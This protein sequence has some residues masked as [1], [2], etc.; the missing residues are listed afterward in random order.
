MSFTDLTVAVIHYQTPELLDR[1]L[2]RLVPSVPGARVLVVD[3]GDAAPLPARW[4]FPG[5]ELIRVAN[6]SFA[7]AVNTALAECRTPFFAHLNADVFVERSTV[8][9]LLA[10]LDGDARI[11]MTGPLAIGATGAWQDQGLPYR[12]W[13]WRVSR[14]WRRAGR[15]NGGRS[16]GFMTVPWLSGCLQVVRMAAV[17]A[18]GPLDDSQRFT[19]EETD[20][21]LR[22]A[23]HGYRSVLVDS[24]AVHLGG[25]STPGNPA[26]LIEGLRGSMVV[27]RRYAPAWRAAV[28]RYAVWGWA[29]LTAVFGLRPATRRTART[30]QQMF[31]RGRFDEA[32]FGETLADPLLPA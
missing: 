26:F 18:A 5:T 8:A 25:A 23:R 24:K 6:H 30:I 29:T 21:C 14:G 27:S 10:V 16:V 32:V 13:Q 9:D 4:S 7:R 28:Q 15:R 12:W 19:N 22:L 17:Q 11:G 1:C 31:R 20:W 3:A 2:H